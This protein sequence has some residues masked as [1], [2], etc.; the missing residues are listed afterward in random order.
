MSEASKDL[1]VPDGYFSDPEI[2]VQF[3]RLVLANELAL[4]DPHEPRV[5]SLRRFVRMAQ[6]EV[7]TLDARHRQA[8]VD[9]S[10]PEV[11]S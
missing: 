3:T 11:E 7:H 8:V 6:D 5:E 1:F 10:Y 2:R 9:S 4:D